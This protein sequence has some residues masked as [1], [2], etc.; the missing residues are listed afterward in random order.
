MG[1]DTIEH[2]VVFEA[3]LQDFEGFM[4]PEAVAY[5]YPWFPLSPFFGLGIE[6][7]LKPLQG[8]IGI[9]ISTVGVCIVP[10][11]GFVRSPVGSMS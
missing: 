8:E 7:K 3:K 9:S 5:Q 2:D 11:R 1:G 4:R 10:P 6:H